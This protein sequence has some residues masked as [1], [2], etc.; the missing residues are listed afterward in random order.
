MEDDL[1]KLTPILSAFQRLSHDS[2]TYGQSLDQVDAQFSKLLSEELKR[3]PKPTDSFSQQACR[4]GRTVLSTIHPPKANEELLKRIQQAC[5]LTDKQVRLL[6]DIGLI[7]TDEAGKP[8]LRNRDEVLLTQEKASWYL[9]ATGC[10]LGM[11]IM[12]IVLEQTPGLWLLVR[13]MGLGIGIGAIAGF[14]LG[15][16]YRAYPVL[17]KLKTL[18][19]WLSTQIAVRG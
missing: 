5:E 1:K 11:A 16:S 14:V 18:E 12:S 2:T 6:R 13:G 4:V 19:P 9:L 8:V 10:L 3:Q 17:E 7:S 15:R